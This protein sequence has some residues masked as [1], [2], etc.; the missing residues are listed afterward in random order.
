MPFIYPKY[1]GDGVMLML[2]QIY[3]FVNFRHKM[4]VSP[5]ISNYVDPPL[6]LEV[7]NIMKNKDI[8]QNEQYW[9][10]VDAEVEVECKSRGEKKVM[11]WAA[12]IN[13][14]MIFYWF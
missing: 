6:P 1:V 14:K 2:L 10:P 3:N 9:A 13:T 5:E 12:F 8:K 4:A 7:E 11:Y